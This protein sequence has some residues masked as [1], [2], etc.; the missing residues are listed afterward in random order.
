MSLKN[1][2]DLFAKIANL[3]DEN[4]LYDEA[5]IADDILQSYANR[6]GIP[7]WDWN[8][9]KE[10]IEQGMSDEEILEKHDVTPENVKEMRKILKE[11]KSKTSYYV[12]DDLLKLANALDQHGFHAEADEVSRVLV[13]FAAEYQGKKVKLNDPI[14]NPA[15]SKKKFRVYVK[16]PKTKNVKKVQFGDPKMEIKRDDPKRRKNFRSR[17]QCDSPAAKDKTKAK[18]WSCYQWRKNKKVD[19]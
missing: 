5:S 15:G 16:D 8:E 18:Y 14:R 2:V 19:N 10:S 17:H 3:L 13:V 9:L 6:P 7:P 1:T 12:I 11:K 4:T